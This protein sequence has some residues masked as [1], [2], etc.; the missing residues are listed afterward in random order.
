MSYGV[1]D[2]ASD[3]GSAAPNSAMP[4]YVRDG[5]V[6]FDIGVSESLTDSGVPLI[7]KERRRTL[8]PTKHAGEE[9]ILEEEEKI[10]ETTVKV[11]HKVKIDI[12]KKYI[13][14]KRC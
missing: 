3:Q 8:K 10:F 9:K 1:S 11:P 7:H 4:R 2:K 13:I 5:A 12:N 6:S 14:R